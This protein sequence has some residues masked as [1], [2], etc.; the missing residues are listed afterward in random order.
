MTAVV[1][2]VEVEVLCTAEE[3]CKKHK[4]EKVGIAALQYIILKRKKA[5]GMKNETRRYTE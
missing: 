1:A 4:S 2:V 3:K 5:Q